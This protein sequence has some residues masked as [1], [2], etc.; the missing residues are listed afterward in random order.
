MEKSAKVSQGKALLN[1][2][3]P[4]YLTQDD[5]KK[6]KTQETEKYN[7][8]YDQNIEYINL[9]RGFDSDTGEVDKKIFSLLSKP[10]LK[11]SLEKL[12]YK[13]NREQIQRL[14]KIINDTDHENEWK[15]DQLNEEIQK[16]QDEIR[17]SEDKRVKQLISDLNKQCGKIKEETNKQKELNRNAII[18]YKNRNGNISDQVKYHLDT[19]LKHCQ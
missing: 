6:I 16:I 18:E 3:G 5:V 13:M 2:R 14:N 1:V 19:I 7:N 17:K 9:I 12:S 11:L 10:E 15:K 4:V 8:F